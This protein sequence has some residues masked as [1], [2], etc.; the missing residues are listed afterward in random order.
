[1]APKTS[2][3]NLSRAA[4]QRQVCIRQPDLWSLDLMKIHTPVLGLCSIDCGTLPFQWEQSGTTNNSNE[5]SRFGTLGPSFL[6]HSLCEKHGEKKLRA[7]QRGQWAHAKP[8]LGVPKKKTFGGANW[9][10]AGCGRKEGPSAW[11]RATDKPDPQAG[12]FIATENSSQC[13][14]LI[15]QSLRHLSG[16]R[17]LGWVTGH[18]GGLKTHHYHRWGA[19]GGCWNQSDS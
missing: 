3:K 15:P 16:Q 8:P 7:E 1:M 11:A 12:P 14:E 13:P 10:K 19:Q 2:R 9:R 5:I 6:S 17:E 18:Q 4:G